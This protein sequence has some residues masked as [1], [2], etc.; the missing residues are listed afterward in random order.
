MESRHYNKIKPYEC[1][2]KIW[3]KQIM[4]RDAEPAANVKA[5]I[6]HSNRLTNWV[7]EVILMQQDVKK[8][9]NVIKHFIA[10]ADVSIAVSFNWPHA[11]TRRNAW[12]CTTSRRSLRSFPRLEQLQSIA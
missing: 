3:K 4:P 2:N 6:L 9:V 1:L 12:L 10:I 5:L 7:A 11:N 8:R